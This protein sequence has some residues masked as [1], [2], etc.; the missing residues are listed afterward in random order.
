[1]NPR[2]VALV[3]SS[4]ETA[5]VIPP[6]TVL[7][8]LPLARRTVLA[9][10]RAGFERIFVA[11]AGSGPW[12]TALNATPA[13]FVGTEPRFP[14]GTAI[15]PWNLVVDTRALQQIRSGTNPQTE[16]IPVRTP[17]D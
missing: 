17:A 13:E 14:E 5:A 1:M 3:A 6:E 8:G 11:D 4:G 9:A 15:L 10:R 12:A 2:A 7:L 16:G